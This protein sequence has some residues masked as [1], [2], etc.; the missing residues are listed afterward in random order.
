M[1]STLSTVGRKCGMDF[2]KVWRALNVTK[3]QACIKAL[4]KEN[5]DLRARAEA[6]ENRADR[7][8]EEVKAYSESYLAKAHEALSADWAKI[9]KYLNDARE[10]NRILCEENDHLK[11]LLKEA[12]IRDV[13]NNTIKSCAGCD[14]LDKENVPCA[15]CLRSVKYADFYKPMPGHTEKKSANPP[16][17]D[18][19]SECY[20]C[21]KHTLLDC[22]KC[23]GR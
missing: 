2:K 18:P 12:G 8:E 9:K 17:K 14:Y 10:A 1:Q 3:E 22:E 6:A 16:W 4:R 19:R 15:H 11:D 13:G 7:W 20:G 21:T 5:V 23:N